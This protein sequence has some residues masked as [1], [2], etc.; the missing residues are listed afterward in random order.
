MFL[1][2]RKY[3]L[4]NDAKRRLEDTAKKLE[5]TTWKGNT[6][7]EVKKEDRFAVAL[8]AIKEGQKK[9]ACYKEETE[10][11]EA[12]RAWNNSVCED[13]C[14]TTYC[15][16][17]KR[18]QEKARWRRAKER[19]KSIDEGE[20]DFDVIDM[21]GNIIRCRRIDKEKQAREEYWQAEYE[22]TKQ[23]R[24]KCLIKQ[25]EQAKKDAKELCALRYAKKLKEK[26]KDIKDK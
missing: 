1:E 14:E 22:Q 19:F 16:A 6:E 25:R 9:I 10:Y 24:M 12:R 3:M 2:N 20:E 15:C 23:R 18:R 5:D 11:Y 7:K 8:D 21:D 26:L 17:W 4:Y 13:P